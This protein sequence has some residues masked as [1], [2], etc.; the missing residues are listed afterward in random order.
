M[1]GLAGLLGTPWHLQARAARAMGEALDHRGPDDAGSWSSDPERG[2]PCTL[3]HRRLSIQDLSA[4]GHQPMASACGRWQLVFNGEIY[5]QHEL[6]RDLERQGHRFRSSSDTEV[7]LQLLIHAGS[8]ALQRLRGMYAFCLWDNQE[9]SALLARDPYGIKPLYLWQGPGGQLLFASEVRALLASGLVPRQLDV[10][11]LAGFLRCGSLPEP[12]TLVAGVQSLPPGWLGEWRAGRWQIQPHWRPS[13]SSGLPISPRARVERTRQAL[14]AA[15]DA[16]QISDVPVG[17]FLS[18]GLDSASLLALAGGSRLTTLSIGFREAAFNE[19]NRAAALARHFGSRHI[20]LQLRASRAA[21]LLP[22]FLA[23]VDQPSIDG[24]NSYCVSKLAADQGLKVVLSGLGGDE[25]FGGYPSFRRLPQL[26][27]LHRRLGPARPAVAHWLARSGQH[28]RQR[29]A[30]LLQGP[31]TPLQAHRTLR[32]LFTA[33]EV[34]AIFRHWGL[35]PAAPHAALHAAA[36]G[37]PLAGLEDADPQPGTERFPQLA[38]A[39]AWL[40]STAYMGQQ[41]LR[42]SDT[43][44]MAHGLELRIP[45]VDAELFRALAPLPAASRLAA[46]KRLLQEAVPEV[47]QAVPPEAKKAFAFPFNVWFDQPDAPL[48][49]GSAAYPL[50]PLPADLDLSPW[51]RRWGLMVLRHWLREHLQ[52]EMA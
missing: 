4:A 32:G 51:A 17:L 43:Y 5:N 12:Q 2:N 30:A 16:H 49:P 7:L 28:Q 36:H 1:C 48:R 26:L 39:I 13:Y 41:L 33:Q 42:D 18:G 47:H 14:E 11:A 38:D 31:A 8:A 23:A 9:Q 44:S 25:L 21:E 29:L 22:A 46:G 52:I 40:E 34:E 15:V 45:F 35:P 20:T 24:F 19:A 27:Q 37:E 50:P 3:V 6:R 10:A